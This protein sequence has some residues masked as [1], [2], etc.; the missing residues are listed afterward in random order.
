MPKHILQ[1][2]AWEK[3]Q[4]SQGYKTF[5]KE[6]KDYTYLAILRKTK[7]GNYLFVPY[8]PAADTKKGQTAGILALK[9]LASRE[10]AIFVRIEPLLKLEKSEEQELKLQKTK[11]LEPKFTRIVN[12]DRPEEEILADI[13]KRKV[14]Y[15]R[16]YAKKGISIKIS[17]DP[18]D[19]DALYRF[20]TE[21]SKTNDFV[22]FDKSYLEAQLHQDF[23]KLYVA[24]FENQ[25]IAAYLIYDDTETRYFVH[26]GTDYEH[27]NLAAG[28]ILVI[29]MMLDAKNNGQKYFDMW[30]VAGDDDPNN[31]W[32]GFTAY[33][34]SFGG[35]QI[36]YGGTYDLVI[37]AKKY[38]LY[39]NLRK[40][41]RLKRKILKK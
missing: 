2:Q 4:Q 14:R 37:D 16:N 22:T 12:L 40:I 20:Y 32:Y 13:E 23:T 28:T 29:Q 25:P 21:I 11:D 30:G 6:T 1:S 19:L 24:Y 7:L 26:G 18:K 41:N 8:G 34:K 31:P 38:K 27:R 3:F 33:K 36:E 9:E 10:N 35:E 17:E 5:Y 15:W 39:Q